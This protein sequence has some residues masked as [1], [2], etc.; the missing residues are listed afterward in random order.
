MGA[1][2]RARRRAVDEVTHR[3]SQWAEASPDVCSLI[4]VGSYAYGKPQIDSDV[5]LVI[6]SDQAD[7]HLASLAFID[8]ITPGG[9]IIR[10]E[11]WGPMHERDAR[12]ASA[13]R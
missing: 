8:S 12:A 7:R 4:L 10:H 9:Q 13:P 2:F 5:D 1:R 3:A 6:L 11:Q